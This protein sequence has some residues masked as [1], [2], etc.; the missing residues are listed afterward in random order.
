MDDNQGTG[1]I[2]GVDYCYMVVAYYSDNAMS[3]ASLEACATL[4]KDVPIITNISINSTDVQ[5]GSAYIAWSKPT[6]FDSL[7]L[8][9][10]YK[11]LIYRSEGL[12]NQNFN[13]ID[14]LTGIND[15]TYIDTFLNTLDSPYNYRIDFYSN[16]ANNRVFVGSTHIASSIFLN[17]TP[18]DNKLT[19]SWNEY[20]PWTNSEYI[21]YKLNPSTLNFDSIFATAD[22]FFVDTGLINGKEYCYKIKSIGKYT[23]SGIINPIVNYSQINCEEPIDL[24]KP[25]SPILQVRTNCLTIE[26]TLTWNNP[27]NSCADD[28]VKY[29]VYYSP[30][31]NG[32]YTIIATI[33]DPKDTVYTHTGLQS[34]AGCY[35]VVAVDSF[36]NKSDF[37]N[38]VCVDIDSCEL[39]SLPNVF[40]PNG[41]GINDLF[42]PFPYNFVDH[43]N[44]QIFNRWGNLVFTT[45]E[46]DI[47]WD[48]KNKDS[49]QLVADGVYFFICHVYEIRLE[50]LVKRTI[51]GSVSV[52]RH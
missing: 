19:L 29:E 18:S 38:V 50:G 23:A 30:I 51:S 33:V 3:Y 15:T 21:I 11:Y 37:S 17:I 22:S 25:C 4:I 47:N 43:I 52:Y 2:H 31:T 16:P 28:V 40:T 12:S 44:I 9:G 7:Q 34:I 1:L 24:E 26:N 6:D 41:D 46:P 42:T 5:N 8:P 20:V 36:M 10:P 13:L 48:G 27:N 39:Y 32:D 49:H 14:S 45:N 35:T